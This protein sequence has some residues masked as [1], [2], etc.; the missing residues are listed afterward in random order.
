[1][2][3]AKRYADRLAV[4]DGR[5]P[6]A[7]AGNLLIFILQIATTILFLQGLLFLGISWLI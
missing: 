1:M 7:P 4:N 2:H 6:G 5:D 3:Y